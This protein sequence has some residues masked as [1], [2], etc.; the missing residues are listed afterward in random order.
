MNIKLMLGI[1]VALFLTYLFFKRLVQHNAFSAEY[2]RQIHE[3]LTD[4]KY[5][6]KGKFD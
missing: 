1:S 5:R 2:H 3:L 6:V 4:E